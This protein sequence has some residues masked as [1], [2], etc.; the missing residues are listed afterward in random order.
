MTLHAIR[1]HPRQDLKAEL[2]NWAR[3]HDIEAAAV[4]TCVGSLQRAVLRFANQADGTVLE[5]KYEIVALTGTLAK[6]GSHFHIALSDGRG[7]TIGG[8]LLE[9]CRIYTTAEIVLA[10]LPEHRFLRLPDAATG[11]EELYITP[12]QQK[13]DNHEY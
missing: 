7:Q 5:D 9:G 2:D 4:V 8:H 6:Y 1:L 3:A 11:Y 13:E 10:P 12:K